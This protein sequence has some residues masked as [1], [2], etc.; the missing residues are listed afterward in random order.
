M[1][2]GEVLY[3]AWALGTPITYAPGE[4]LRIPSALPDELQRAARAHE[5]ELVAILGDR[6]P[7]LRD[8]LTDGECLVARL[9]WC[10]LTDRGMPRELAERLSAWMVRTRL[11]RYRYPHE[12]GPLPADDWAIQRR[13]AVALKQRLRARYRHAA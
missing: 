12:R 13:A 11:G 1:H 4:G 2:A 9:C 8:G 7:S 5:D 6:L 10:D 3:R